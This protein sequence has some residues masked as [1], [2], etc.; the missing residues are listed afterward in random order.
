[1]KDKNVQRPG[2]QVHDV[3]ITMELEGANALTILFALSALY[4]MNDKYH[5]VK[6]LLLEHHGM[7]CEI[8]KLTYLLFPSFFFPLFSRPHSRK[9][10]R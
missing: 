4:A 7:I 9:D 6:S 8:I 3:P 10:L 5:Q 2:L 1:M